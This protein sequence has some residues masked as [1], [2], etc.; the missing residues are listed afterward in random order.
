MYLLEGLE[1]TP[2]PVKSLD[3]G[4]W[5]T[6]SPPSVP[7]EGMVRL[8]CLTFNPEAMARFLCFMVYMCFLISL[9][10]GAK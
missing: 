7:P 5:T 3:P 10:L 6:L 2:L 1:N 4:T 9:T 8:S